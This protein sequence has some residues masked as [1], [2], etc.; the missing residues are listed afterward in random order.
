M[1][2][3][4]VVPGKKFCYRSSVTEGVLLAQSMYFKGSIKNRE[5]Y[6]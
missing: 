5:M 1:G 3:Q 6:V 4:K 2:L